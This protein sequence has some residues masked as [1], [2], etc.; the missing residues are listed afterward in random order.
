MTRINFVRVLLG[1]VVAA[2]ILFVIS[3]IVDGAILGNQWRAW[4]QSLG[5]AVHPPAVGTEMAVWAV[6]NLIV[7]ITG[8]WIYAAIRPRYGPGPPTALIAGFMVWV[9]TMLTA[10]LAHI[11]FGDMPP[12]NI[13]I[14]DLVTGLLRAQL[15]LL[16]G[17]A[18]YKE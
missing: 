17:G 15:A 10:A 7:G 14:I 4:Q 8:V 6:F 5:P 3:G 18:I 1:G 13:V 2:I 12:A 9:L 11:A 16:A